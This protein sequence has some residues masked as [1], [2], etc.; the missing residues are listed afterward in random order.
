MFEPVSSRPDFVAQEHDLLRVWAD[1]RTFARLRAQKNTH[2]PRA[3]RQR[4]G[5][6]GPQGAGSGAGAPALVVGR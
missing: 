6:R 5:P 1:R 3:V 2:R 4:T